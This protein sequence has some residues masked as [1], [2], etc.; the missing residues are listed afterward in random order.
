MGGNSIQNNK[1]RFRAY[2]K[3]RLVRLHVCGVDTTISARVQRSSTCAD[4]EGGKGFAP[5]DSNFFKL[6]YRITKKNSL[7]TAWQTQITV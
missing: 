3:T 7:G 4:P 1:T 2:C 5:K 6:L